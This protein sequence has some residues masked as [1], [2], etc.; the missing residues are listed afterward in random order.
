MRFSAP[1][2]ETAEVIIDPR[3]PPLTDVVEVELEVAPAPATLTLRISIEL[4][5]LLA[6][7]GVDLDFYDLGA[8]TAEDARRTA[9]RFY[10]MG[11]GGKGSAALAPRGARLEFERTQAGLRVGE[12]PLPPL[13]HLGQPDTFQPGDRG[14]GKPRGHRAKQLFKA[15]QK[16]SIR[17]PA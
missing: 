2:F 13:V 12:I 3:D 6:G 16:I 8:M 10:R 1:G 4:R 11:S 17:E 14:W 9:Q 15:G 5:D 7:V